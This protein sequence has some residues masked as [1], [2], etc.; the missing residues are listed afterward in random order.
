M[1]YN[2]RSYYY[3]SVFLLLFCFMVLPAASSASTE[4]IQQL[5]A[6]GKLQQ[7]LQLT[8]EQIQ[9]D[10]GNVTYLFMKGL[11]LTK[12]NK[13]EQ[14]RDVFIELTNSHPELPEPYNNLAVV[15]AA[16]GE[17]ENART[18]LQRAI[19]THPSYATAHENMGDIYAKMASHAYSQALELDSD[20]NAAKTKL[21]LV[22]E[23]FSVPDSTTGTKA[24]KTTTALAPADVA[25]VDTTEAVIPAAETASDIEEVKADIQSRI[26]EWAQAWSDQNPDAYLSFYA[27]DFVP[28]KKLSRQSWEQNRQ[29]RIK[30]PKFIKV[31]VANIQVIM[32]GTE[33]AQ[34]IF[35]QKY[36]SDTYQDSVTKVMLL[37]QETGIWYIAE[38]TSK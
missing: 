16:M 4:K 26:E 24:T 27:G 25:E 20:N 13:L 30:K 33:H 32:H 9:G 15:Y 28:P 36:Q 2:Y 18:A 12:L 19:N 1:I 37:K 21:A 10:K 29:I 31:E 6:A 3:R 11:I 35:S 5:V 14:A 22:S 34:A 7:A 23:L 8:E 17:F 38:E